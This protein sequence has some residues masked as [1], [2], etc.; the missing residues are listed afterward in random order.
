MYYQP[1][2]RRKLEIELCRTFGAKTGLK[3]DGDEIL[4]D[5]P[6]LGKSPE[7]N[8]NVFF[9]SYIPLDKADPLRFD[10]PEVS[11]LK[12]YLIGNFETQAKVVR[13]FCVDHPILRET[14]KAEVI[15]HMTTA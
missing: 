8:L 11:M 9:G 14:L 1:A 12:E 5:I 15:D 6:R 3:L 2:D 13:I 4:I 7:V 10:D